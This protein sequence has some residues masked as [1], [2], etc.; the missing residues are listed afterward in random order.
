MRWGDCSRLQLIEV[1]TLPLA[2]TVAMTSDQI[3]QAKQDLQCQVRC[4]FTKQQS[5]QRASEP[6]ARLTWY[7]RR[8]NLQQSCVSD[9]CLA[10]PQPAT[11]PQ[12]LVARPVKAEAFRRVPVPIGLLRMQRLEASE[13]IYDHILEKM[14]KANLRNRV[15]CLL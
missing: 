14:S 13:A 2:P 8:K 1:Q 15:F 5:L 7:N 10:A 9:L 11:M 12:E 3:E 6:C 4:G